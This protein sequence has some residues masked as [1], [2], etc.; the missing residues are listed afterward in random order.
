MKIRPATSQDI[1][2]ILN[3][4]H[5]KATFDRCPQTVTATPE[6]L[7]NT[8]FTP[9]PIA[10]ILLAEPTPNAPIG[11]A[12]YHFTYSTF[13]AQPSLWL[14]DLFIHKTHRNQSTGTHLIRTLCQIAQQKGC[15]R[16][17]W[18]VDTQNQSA[19]RFYQRIGAQLQ[20]NVHLCRLTQPN[21]HQNSQ[22]ISQ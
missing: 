21:I 13:L 6:K 15:G 3:L 22:A 14:D 5:L 9:N 16:I 2:Q 19:I 11:F 8:L 7:Q 4:I 10:H 1:P 20:T 18:T 17:D 12:S